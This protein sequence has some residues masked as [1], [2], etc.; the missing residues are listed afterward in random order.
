MDIE[1]VARQWASP[2][3]VVLYSP[4]GGVAG[5]QQVFANRGDFGIDRLIERQT[6]V[7]GEAS[8]I[9]DAMR[10][11]VSSGINSTRLYD[12]RLESSMAAM[13]DIFEPFNAF[14]RRRD[15]MLCGG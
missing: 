3:G 5:P 1:E 10:G 4:E 15:T 11:D 14:L 12:M 9:T 7:M 2:D 13:S 6:R 8:G